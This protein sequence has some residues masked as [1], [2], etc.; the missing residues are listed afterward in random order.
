MI[1]L[2]SRILF[3]LIVVHSVY[4]QF[5]QLETDTPY[6]FQTNVAYGPDEKM[7]FDLWSPESESFM[8]LIIFY[9]GGGFDHGDKREIQH[10]PHHVRALARRAEK[11]G[12]DC[13]LY[14]ASVE[15][16]EDPVSWVVFM[17]ERLEGKPPSP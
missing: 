13:R 6:H 12:V 17:I 11:V 16:A 2:Q 4:C 14:S 1:H 10:H 7:A 3:F 5:P 15:S 8:P 9:H